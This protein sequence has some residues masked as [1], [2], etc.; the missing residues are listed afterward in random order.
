MSKRR[1]G[2]AVSGEETHFKGMVPNRP[3]ER[4]RLKGLESGSEQGFEVLGA[5]SRKIYF[6]PSWR[7]SSGTL[8]RWRV[9]RVLK[10]KGLSIRVR[11]RVKNRRQRH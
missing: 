1:E 6:G 11:W 8:E 10:G 9:A 5:A 3:Q 7:I 2:S 4:G